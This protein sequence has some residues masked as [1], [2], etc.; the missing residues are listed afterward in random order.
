MCDYVIYAMFVAI[1]ATVWLLW[2]LVSI[3]YTHMLYKK[4]RKRVFKAYEDNKFPI[5]DMSEDDKLEL[6]T[7][8]FVK[9]SHKVLRRVYRR[10]F[11]HGKFLYE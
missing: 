2:E 1:G 11:Y 9:S 10:Y 8:C 4:M 6:Y 3:L 5:E 7:A